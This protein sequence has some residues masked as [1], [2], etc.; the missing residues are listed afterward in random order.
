MEDVTTSERY[1]VNLRLGI[2]MAT[3]VQRGQVLQSPC[4]CHVKNAF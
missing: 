3:R 1:F 2:G 4:V